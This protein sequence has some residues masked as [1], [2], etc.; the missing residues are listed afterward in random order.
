VTPNI[1]PARYP[2]LAQKSNLQHAERIS[3]RLV[4][5]TTCE[6][7]LSG[8]VRYDSIVEGPAFTGLAPISTVQFVCCGDRS[9]S[10]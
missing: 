9:I 6:G 2:L 5:G 4:P 7:T 8:L 3:N 1:R 10:S